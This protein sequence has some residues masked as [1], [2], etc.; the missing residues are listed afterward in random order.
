M[1]DEICPVEIERD[2][3]VEHRLT[4]LE[5]NVRAITENHLPHIDAKIEKLF[6]KMD[7]AQ[8]LVITTLV[9]VIIGLVLI[10]FKR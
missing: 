4:G 10:F 5:T 3:N 8:I 1:K 7:R 2:L 9:S 6:N